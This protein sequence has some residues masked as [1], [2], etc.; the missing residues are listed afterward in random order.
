MRRIRGLVALGVGLALLAAACGGE[1]KDSN[2]ALP[3]P[4]ETPAVAPDPATPS[5]E[6]PAAAPTVSLHGG[7]ESRR[8]AGT[9][10]SV[11]PEESRRIAS[12]TEVS[13]RTSRRCT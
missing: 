2:S 1:Q 5:A 12:P 6:D 7:G 13:R 4:A 8:P 3:A 11:S 9:A 10:R